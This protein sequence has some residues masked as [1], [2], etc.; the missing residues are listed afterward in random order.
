MIISY[1]FLGADSQAPTRERQPWARQQRY[2]G[3]QRAWSLRMLLGHLCMPVNHPRRSFWPASAR[4]YDTTLRSGLDHPK[5]LM[6]SRRI[7]FQSISPYTF[8]GLTKIYPVST[9]ASL[10][11]HIK[12]HKTLAAELEHAE[13]RNAGLVSR[14]VALEAEL[15]KFKIYT[16]N[17]GKEY[18]IILRM[19]AVNESEDAWCIFPPCK[20]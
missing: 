2:E 20:S 19:N 11:G 7:R 4:R 16:R 9:F 1:S 6:C 10:L 5:R 12:P 17:S 15:A 18:N 3:D 14:N 13:R 8:Y